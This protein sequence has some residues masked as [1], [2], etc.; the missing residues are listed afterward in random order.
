MHLFPVGDPS[1]KTTHGEQN[2]KHLYRNPDCPVDDARIKV[3]VGI[4]LLFNEVGILEC[5][6]LK[7]FGNIEDRVGLIDFFQQLVWY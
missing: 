1:W 3:D 2:R 4:Q 6:F 5:H 7:F